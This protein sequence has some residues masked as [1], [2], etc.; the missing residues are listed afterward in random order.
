MTDQWKKSV[1][2]L[3]HLLYD[4]V[5]KEF[6]APAQ[7]GYGLDGGQK[8]RQSDFE[9][10]RGKF[11][12]NVLVREIEQHIVNKTRLGDELITRIKKIC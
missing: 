11:E 7:I 9:A 10:V 2:N 4:D 1:V 3:D 6:T 5:R 8:E 12:K